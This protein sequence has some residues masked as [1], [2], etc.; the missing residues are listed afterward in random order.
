MVER[1]KFDSQEHETITAYGVWQEILDTHP[2][3]VQ[4][5]LVVYPPHSHGEAPG[6]FINQMELVYSNLSRYSRFLKREDN[7]V[8]AVGAI[9]EVC[10][11]QINRQNRVVLYDVNGKD[12][13]LGSPKALTFLDIEWHYDDT[14]Q[15]LLQVLADIAEDGYILDSGGGYHFILTKLGLVSNLPCRYGEVIREVGKSIDSDKLS[16]WGESLLNTNNQRRKV[17]NWC[18]HVFDHC[19]HVQDSGEKEVHLVDLRHV[20]HGLEKLVNSRLWLGNFS[21]NSNSSRVRGES[22]GGPCLRI[23]PSKNYDRPPVLVAKQISGELTCYDSQRPKLL[24]L[25]IRQRCLL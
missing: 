20:A 14:E 5:Y 15:K 8:C 2:E 11:D 4:L 3:I 23:S 18:R 25:D 21:G 22:V 6:E 17:L 1:N 9:V 16:D 19:G 10:D 24:G 12:I 13:F 7:Q